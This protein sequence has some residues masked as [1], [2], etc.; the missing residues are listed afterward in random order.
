LTS[1]I[2]F[3]MSAE[4]A[5][6]APLPSSLPP[7]PPLPPTVVAASSPTHPPQQ[8]PRPP[9]LRRVAVQQPPSITTSLSVP[10]VGTF[11][12]SPTPASAVSFSGVPFSPYA[13]SANLTPGSTLP[14]STTSFGPS[15]PMASRSSAPVVAY[16]PQEW[17]RHG[18]VAGNYMPHTGSSSARNS[19][20]NRTDNM[21]G[22]E[23]KWCH[24]TS[25]SSI[26][27]GA[28]VNRLTLAS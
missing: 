20:A 18:P 10:Q 2:R 26:F 11:L 8:V 17:N 21:T 13:S 25:F 27:L 5:R 9:P 4:H 14:S 12:A 16:N 15:S 6:A 24:N 22:M 7:P 3:A 1:A 28:F 19:M 23:G